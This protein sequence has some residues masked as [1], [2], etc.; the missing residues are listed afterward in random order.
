MVVIEFPQH[1]NYYELV[2]MTGSSAS[3]EETCQCLW[4]PTKS[5]NPTPKL[6]GLA[7]L[8]V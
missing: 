8:A 3:V 4:S 2:V 1:L 7:P 6:T 5:C